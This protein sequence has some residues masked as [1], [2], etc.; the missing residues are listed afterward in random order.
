MGL[1]HILKTIANILRTRSGPGACLAC[2][3]ALDVR[4]CTFPGPLRSRVLSTFFAQLPAKNLIPRKCVTCHSCDIPNHL[5]YSALMCRW[6]MYR[7]VV[8][9]AKPWPIKIFSGAS[10][11]TH[12]PQTMGR[13]KGVQCTKFEEI[14]WC[15]RT[16]LC[17]FSSGQPDHISERRSYLL[18]ANKPR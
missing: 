16:T 3:A 18:S 10:K 11:P 14:H 12:S 1:L 4:N 13:S 5:W 6:P 9:V 7:V 8:R 17:V 2:R 15:Q